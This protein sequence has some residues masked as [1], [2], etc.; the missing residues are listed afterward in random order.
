MPPYG[1]HGFTAVKALWLRAVHS[2]IAFAHFLYVVAYNLR[3]VETIFTNTHCSRHIRMKKADNPD[4]R[5]AM[6][7]ESEAAAASSSP[8]SHPPTSTDEERKPKAAAM[9]EARFRPKGYPFLAQFWSHTQ[10]GMARKF[11][12]LAALNILYLQAEL[13]H[14]ERELERQRRS[15]LE[16]GRP[17]RGD[18]DW[19]WLVLSEPA[20]HRGSRQW[21]VVLEIREK[22]GEYHQNAN[23]KFADHRRAT[24]SAL[25]QYSEMTGLAVPTEEQR[26]EMF[27]IVG[28]SSLNERLG[29]FQSV[30]LAG[31]EGPAAY[32]SEN[33][34]DLMLLDGKEE[35]NDI[36]STWLVEPFFRAVHCLCKRH[37]KTLPKDLESAVAAAGDDN[38]FG[39]YMYSAYHYDFVN[40]IVGAL[41]GSATPL[42]SMVILYSVRSNNAKIG[43]VCVFTLLFCLA[44][45]TL[46]K[47]RRIEVFAATAA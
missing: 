36:L 30:D 37:K 31:V 25:L 3:G 10:T 6:A 20:L 32:G 1:C 22:L 33:T 35:E 28:S 16:T 4:K 21:E 39:V 45:S 15:D 26:K 38:D 44:L 29:A 23:Q 2:P 9:A 34:D 11:K 19:N 18:C 8:R 17:E 27:K 24:D 47:V 46:S 5:N 7:A 40:R 41:V 43:L 42:A 14:L 12:R 13:S